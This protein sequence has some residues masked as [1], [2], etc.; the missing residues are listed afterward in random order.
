MKRFYILAITGL[1][2]LAACI[3]TQKLIN[4]GRYDEA[5]SNSVQKLR[6]NKTKEKEILNLEEAF[7]KAQKRDLDRINFLRKEG[8]PTNSVEIYRLYE[9]M[10]LRQKRIQPLLPLYLQDRQVNFN[11]LNIDDEIIAAKR[12]AAGYLYSHAMSL[13]EKPDKM[14]ARQAF[15]ELNELKGLFP[16][17]RDVDERTREAWHRGMNWITFRVE[18]NSL[19]LIPSEFA[20]ELRH[21]DLWPSEGKWF[22]FLGE[23]D[24]DSIA[25]FTVV[26]NLKMVDVGPEQIK[27][28]HYEETKEIQTGEKNLLDEKGNVVKD[29]AGNPIKVPI[30][31]EVSA[32]II[33]TQQTKVAMLGGS[34]EFYDIPRNRFVRSDP[35]SIQAIFEHYSATFQGNKEALKEETKRKIGNRPVPFPSDFGMIMDG[36]MRLQPIVIDIIRNNSWVLEST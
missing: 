29:T 8:N 17:Y 34:V 26:V 9:Y 21:T 14:S 30:L 2:T 20:Y 16:N 5:I 10:D 7:A 24:P 3:N 11:F 27:E 23:N 28:V 18:N 35:F 4:S 12:E 15:D 36:A 22:R 6:K 33:E 31:K 13:L 19:N 25:D 1:F 32:Y